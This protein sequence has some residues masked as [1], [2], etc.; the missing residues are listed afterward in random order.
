MPLINNNKSGIQSEFFVKKT[1]RE[2]RGKTE[3]YALSFIHDNNLM[4]VPWPVSY[5]PEGDKLLMP[6]IKGDL[7]IKF[8]RDIRLRNPCNKFLNEEYIGSLTEAIIDEVIASIR[9]IHSEYLE[10]QPLPY[11]KFTKYQYKRKFIKTIRQINNF[12]FSQ[13]WRQ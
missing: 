13:Q 9:G 6:I 11:I 8:L 3:F 5:N 4:P 12:S 7:L 10:L 2:G 1:G